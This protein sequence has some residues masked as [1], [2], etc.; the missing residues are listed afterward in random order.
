M[1]IILGFGRFKLK[2]LKSKITGAT[3]QKWKEKLK[4]K[5]IWKGSI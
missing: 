4:E 2:Y 3:R 1:L 5:K